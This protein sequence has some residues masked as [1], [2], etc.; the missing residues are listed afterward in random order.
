MNEAQA[1]TSSP[2]RQTL[3]APARRAD[4][5]RRLGRIDIHTNP[6]QA[7]AAWAFLEAARSGSLRWLLLGAFIVGLGFNIKMLQA[8][9]PLPAFY[10]LYFFGARHTFWKKTRHL[11][12]AT[13]L[14]L[15]VS[16]AWVAAV[17]LT[18][19][20]NRPY[21]DSTSSNSAFE[22]IASCSA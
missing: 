7:D 14:L 12:A 4:E 9:L 22:S 16:F 11:A 10:A 18:P 19:A 1:A 3:D 13:A 2:A 5:S 6:D 21:V 20:A 17:D 15:L 8:F